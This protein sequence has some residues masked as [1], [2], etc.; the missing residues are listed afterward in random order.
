MNDDITTRGL[1]PK[2]FLSLLIENPIIIGRRGST[3]GAK[4]VSTP[5]IN[6]MKIR[7]NPSSLTIK[8]CREQINDCKH[9]KMLS[10]W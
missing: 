4:I 6:E 1:W 10:S 8:K 9:S 5:D 7:T 2:S 3:Q